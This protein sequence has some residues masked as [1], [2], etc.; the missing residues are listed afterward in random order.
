MSRRAPPEPT[1]FLSRLDQAVI[2]AADDYVRGPCDG[3][4]A[5][6]RHRLQKAVWERWWSMQASPRAKRRAAIMGAA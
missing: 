2:E 5:R 3:H 4:K 1:L 6:R